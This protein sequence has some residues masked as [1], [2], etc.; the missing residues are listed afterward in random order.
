MDIQD[1]AIRGNARGRYDQVWV[2][3]GFDDDSCSNGRTVGTFERT[4][5]ENL[6]SRPDLNAKHLRVIVESPR[7][8]PALASII[9]Q[10]LI[11]HQ[12]SETEVT[13]STSEAL[14]I[15]LRE[16]HPAT[17]DQ[18]I[19]KSNV[20]NAVPP[21]LQSNLANAEGFADVYGSDVAGRIRGVGQMY[22]MLKSGSV[23]NRSSAKEAL[24]ARLADNELAVIKA[25]Y[26]RSDEAVQA[27]HEDYTETLRSVFITEKQNVAVLRCH[28]RF[29]DGH[30]IHAN[31]EVAEE[32][33]ERLIFPC[34]L[35]TGDRQISGREEW[36][37]F[38]DAGMGGMDL[39]KGIKAAILAAP[40]VVSGDA[41]SAQLNKLVI[42]QLSS[43][44]TLYRGETQF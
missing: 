1:Q 29:I 10:G 22:D 26:A 43:K 33:F 7:L 2:R 18:S 8:S 20:Q 16:R 15:A 11:S 39:V 23:S 31:P 44:L 37:A 30:L 32:V 5:R 3:D 9:A 6:I 19:M 36:E 17:V 24:K 27:L 34:L 21:A 38:S 35:S 40:S 14:L 25:I 28:I 42:E 41:G 12:S 13:R 4:N